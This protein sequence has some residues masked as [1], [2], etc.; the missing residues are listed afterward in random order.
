MAQFFNFKEDY[1]GL[2]ESDID[3]NIALYGFNIYTKNE[4]AMKEYTPLNV[5]YTYV[6]SGSAMLFRCG[7]RLWNSGSAY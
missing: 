1:Y 6:C 4:K 7:D 3:K 5:I 2:T